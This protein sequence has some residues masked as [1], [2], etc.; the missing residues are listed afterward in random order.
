MGQAKHH[1]D[2]IAGASLRESLLPQDAIARAVR[3]GVMACASGLGLPGGLCGFHAA[4]GRAVLAERFG[5]AS[6]LAAGDFQRRVTPHVVHSYAGRGGRIDAASGACH[7][8]LTLVA[9]GATV[10]FDAWE[11]PVRYD[12]TSRPHGPWTAPRPDFY[13]V[14]AGALAP[15]LAAVRP[16]RDALAFVEARLSRPAERGFIA[17]ACAAA[18]Q[19]LGDRAA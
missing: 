16:D 5:I 8:W 2:A 4:V 18:L 9:S 10:D 3:D 6:R 7:V 11:E 1:R 19:R 14:A 12:A 13:W 17:A 15:G